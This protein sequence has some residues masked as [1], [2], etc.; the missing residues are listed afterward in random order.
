MPF[1][2]TRSDAVVV[3]E[4]VGSRIELNTWPNLGIVSVCNSVTAR[5]YRI[6]QR[7]RYGNISTFPCKVM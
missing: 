7:I 3:V 4:E 6:Y 1:H 5:I 2:A